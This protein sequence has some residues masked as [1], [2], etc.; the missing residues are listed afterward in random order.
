MKKIF[1]LVVTVLCVTALFAQAP[2]KFTYQ[3]VVRNASNSLVSNA[4]V[5]VRVSILQGS[6]AG[7]PVY[8]ETQTVTTNANGLLT[9]EIGGGN[10]LQ[11]TFADIDWA[12]GP[13]FLKTETDPNG[14]GNYNITSTQ[15]MLSV[16][17]ALYASEAGNVPT[18]SVIP[19]DTGYVLELIPAEGAPQ[20]YILRNGVDGQQGP[21][22][23]PGPAGAIGPQGPQG[24]QGPA[25]ATGEQGP[26][27]EQGSQGL[28]GA[29]G[30]DGFSP[31][32]VTTSAGDS[33][34]VTITDVNGPH[35]FVIYNGEDGADGTGGTGLAQTLSLNGYTL[36][37]SG[38]NS[39]NLP[40]GFS[41]NYNDLTNKP[42]IPTVPTNVGAFSNDAGYITSADIPEIPTVPTNISAFDNDAGYINDLSGIMALLNTLQHQI[43]SLGAALDS[44][45][46]ALE[47]ATAFHCGAS[48][49]SDHE[50]NTYHTVQIG[51]QCWLRENMRCITSPKG[52]SFS[53][54]IMETWEHDNIIDTAYF[55]ANN[56]PQYYNNTG[57][58]VDMTTRGLLYNAWAALDTLLIISNSPYEVYGDITFNDSFA[59]RRGICPKGWHIPTQTEWGVLGSYVDE[60]VTDCHSAKAL[61][62]VE[63]WK[64]PEWIPVDELGSCAPAVNASY[65]NTTRFSAYPAGNFYESIDYQTNVISWYSESGY[66][67]QFWGSGGYSYV[68]PGYNYSSNLCNAS[69]YSFDQFLNVYG[70]DSANS[71]SSVRCLKD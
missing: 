70:M 31:T 16:P 42:T 12:N 64:A 40:E 44:T 11:G 20:T 58:T 29:A 24:E 59:G 9:L 46:N 71:F 34:V 63:G 25:G 68:S 47:E 52:Y 2:E 30:A 27:G 45:R 6:A 5:G 66:V 18:I 37:I 26:Q 13:F 61:A 7:N 57:I 32:V 43:D 50:G 35:T 62:T 60:H 39:V 54:L 15:Q 21:Q 10:V 48:T 41:G 53:A 56:Y 14:G 23:N 22:G 28:P 51:D 67:A 65:N 69:I 19:T 55:V 1:T 3:A 36:S 4:S 38:G 8:V 33:T 17:Y 49:V